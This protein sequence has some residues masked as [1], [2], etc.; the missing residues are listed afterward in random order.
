MRNLLDR[1]EL[2]RLEKAA[3]EKD[4]KHLMEWAIAY[5]DM[6]RKEYEKA[7]E[8]EI[9]NAIDNFL[10]AIAYTLHFNEKRVNTS[11]MSIWTN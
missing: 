6:L 3:R 5:E 8:D 10:V 2:R 1:N 7:Y 9:Q 11:Q 4:K